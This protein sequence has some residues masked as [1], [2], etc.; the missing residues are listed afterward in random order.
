MEASRRTHSRCARPREAPTS[1]LTNSAFSWKFALRVE[2]L[3]Y[4]RL[5]RLRGGYGVGV[6]V[7]HLPLTLFG[8]EDHRGAHGVWDELVARADLGLGPL[9]LHH[10]G[11]LGSRVLRYDL[12]SEKLP[13]LRNDA[14]C[15][16]VLATS[17]HPRM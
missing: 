15:S 11:Q 4:D 16:V 10:E 1:A 13:S 7:H 2:L 17:S 3:L 6:A 14:A 9:Y 12:V 5:C 8:A